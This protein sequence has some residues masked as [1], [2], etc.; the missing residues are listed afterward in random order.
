MQLHPEAVSEFRFIQ[1]CNPISAKHVPA[2]GGWVREV[3]FDG[4]RGQAHKVGS[5]IVISRS[6]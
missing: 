4:Y 1:P 2:G 6:W 5:R 3:K